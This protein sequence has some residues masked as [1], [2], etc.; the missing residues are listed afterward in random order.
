MTQED[1]LTFVESRREVEWSLKAITGSPKQ[2]ED[3]E[4]Y[5]SVLP[6][7]GAIE[8]EFKTFEDDFHTEYVMNSIAEDI[9]RTLTSQG[10]LSS[11]QATLQTPPGRPCTKVEAFEGWQ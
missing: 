3:S 10:H 5:G 7:E 11:R 4:P 9:E 6:A 1:H 8:Y 2:R